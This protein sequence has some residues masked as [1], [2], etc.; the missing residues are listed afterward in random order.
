MPSILILHH[1]GLGDHIMCH[2]I[3]REYAKRYDKIGLFCLPHNHASVAFM[4]R[5]IPGF[6]AIKA[7]EQEAR[8]YIR[9]NAKR[10]D[11]SRYDK[12]KIIGFEF[13]DKTSD[14]PLEMQFYT[15]AGIDISKKWDSFK[16]N[17]DRTL[18]KSLFTKAAPEKQY[19][20]IHEDRTR[21][22]TID[23][24]RIDPRLAEFSP[25]TELAENFFDYATIIENAAEIHVIDSS[26]MFMID[27]LDYTNPNQKLY[28]HRYARENNE[29]QLPILRKDWVILL[30]LR[31]ALD[32]LKAGLEK[33]YNTEIP[34]LRGSFVK[35]AI[36]RFFRSIG[37]SMGRPQNPPVKNLIKR[38]VPKKSFLAIGAHGAEFAHIAKEAASSLTHS[39]LTENLAQTTP[40]S[41]VLFDDLIAD[42]ARLENIII[43]LRKVT[44]EILILRTVRLD[45]SRIIEVARLAGFD[46]RE[47]HLFPNENCFVF[48]AI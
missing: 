18:E 16:V 8:E 14:V 31:S 29:W 26:F 13:L 15:L 33:L 28:I 23:R 20:F 25:R 37:S 17:R 5:D 34:L 4:F 6:T 21:S 12:T 41:I 11:G 30:P 44:Q 43:S 27:C 46:I 47:R 39:T 3:I 2:G 40:A 45:E 42:I 9:T 38:Y 7:T 10:T 48:R 19:A 35:R 32:P 22:Y 36:R 24:K 1:L